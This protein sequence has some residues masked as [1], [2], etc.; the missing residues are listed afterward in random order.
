LHAEFV[1]DWLPARV[2]NLRW[3]PADF[4]QS[5]TKMLGDI[6][7][8]WR[9][10]RWREGSVDLNNVAWRADVE[11]AIRGLSDACFNGASNGFAPIRSQS[12]D[13][14]NRIQTYS[15]AQRALPS[16]LLI[17][18]TQSGLFLVD[19]YHRVTWY[20]F[21][22]SLFGQGFPV[23]PIASCYF[24]RYEEEHSVSS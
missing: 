12:L 18:E 3:P 19:G 22:S 9:L 20:K 15:L 17:A 4:H 16:R 7:E 5:W 1:R 10:Y 23:S 13:K 11:P 6:P 21:T 14:I 24:G 8:R 2:R